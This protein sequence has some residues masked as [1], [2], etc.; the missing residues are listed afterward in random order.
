MSQHN[1]HMKR[2][3]T[4]VHFLWV[5]VWGIRLCVRNINTWLVDLFLAFSFLYS[6]TLPSNDIF[7]N[8]SRYFLSYFFP[9]GILFTLTRESE[10]E[11]D[12]EEEKFVMSYVQ[13][14][15]ITTAD[16]KINTKL[17]CKPRMIKYSEIL[18]WCSLKL[19][20]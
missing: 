14:S 12:R 1:I 17:Y 6:L 20:E 10:R 18:W 13:H 19:G 5:R 11:R 8:L 7:D 15:N 4:G 3:T 9:Y 2:N 16:N